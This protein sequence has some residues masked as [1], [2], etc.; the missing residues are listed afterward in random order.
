[1]LAKAPASNPFLEAM[2]SQ[3]PIGLS[4]AAADF[5]NDP[6][7]ARLEEIKHAAAAFNAGRGYTKRAR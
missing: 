3:G 2:D 1:M 5:T 4:T 7:A 6:K